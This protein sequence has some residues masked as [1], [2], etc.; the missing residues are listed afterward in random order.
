MGTQCRNQ[1]SYSIHNEE[2]RNDTIQNEGLRN[3]IEYRMK[4][5][6]MTLHAQWRN[7]KWYCIHNEDLR[8]D[9]QYTM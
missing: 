5:S 6:E 4:N 9:I 8:N 1:K 3:D 2:L 7:E